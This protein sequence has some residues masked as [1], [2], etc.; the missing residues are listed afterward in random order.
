MLYLSRRVGTQT[1][2]AG[3]AAGGSEV[4]G[5]RANAAGSEEAATGA[6]G[7]ALRR[8]PVEGRGSGGPLS[9]SSSEEDNED[10]TGEEANEPSCTR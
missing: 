3:G 6:R 1:A 10:V 2:A 8:R 7:R 5:W 9:T 4:E